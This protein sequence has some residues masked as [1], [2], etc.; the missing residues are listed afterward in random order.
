MA[1]TEWTVLPHDPIE[2]LEDN[3]WRVQG[4]VPGMPLKRVM[5]IA[6][7]AD[8]KLVIHNAMALEE[9]AMKEIEAFGE[10]GFLVVPNGWHRIDAPRF[11]A[12]YPAIRVVCPKGARKKVEQVVPV[13]TDYA[14]YPS[15]PDVALETLAGVA[16]AEGVMTVRS[17]DNVTLVF[18]DMVFNMPHLGGAQGFV[19]K[20][21]TASSGGPKLSRVA[22]WFM[23]KDKAAFRGELERLAETK[24]LVRVIVGHHE[25]IEREADPAG[26]LRR[27]AETI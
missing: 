27:V 23:L 5:T 22:R 20:H 18:N 7:R 15:D 24:G 17:S 9:P 2:K 8:G 11:K 16:D 10:P 14:G 1:D 6:K 25:T 19:L 13:D 21:V 12:R 4:S 3:L 26:V